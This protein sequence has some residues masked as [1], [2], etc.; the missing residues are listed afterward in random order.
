M[1]AIGLLVFL[2]L[3]AAC[4]GIVKFFTWLFSIQWWIYVIILILIIGIIVLVHFIK[5]KHRKKASTLIK[6]EDSIENNSEEIK[7]PVDEKSICPR[8]G[9]LLV[10]RH[11]PY[12]DFYGCEN[13]S[14]KNCRYTRRFK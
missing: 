12:G 5:Y 6:K 11:G 14:S 3:S 10:K 4:I 1:I 13:Y 9:G 8:C 2:G 7:E